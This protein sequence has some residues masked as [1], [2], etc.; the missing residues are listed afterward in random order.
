MRSQLLDLLYDLFDRDSSLL[1]SVLSGWSDSIPTVRVSKYSF[2]LSIDLHGDHLV[3]D[4]HFPC[5]VVWAE[6]GCTSRITLRRSLSTLRIVPR[7]GSP[8]RVICS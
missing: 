4:I 7:D 8:S 6:V 3:L 5:C 2:R 1:K